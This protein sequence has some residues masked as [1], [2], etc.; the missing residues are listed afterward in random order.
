MAQDLRL[1]RTVYTAGTCIFSCVQKTQGGSM[2]HDVN[3]CSKTKA[4]LLSIFLLSNIN[5]YSFSPLIIFW[6]GFSLLK[7]T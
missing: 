4:T 5:E 7:Y 6:P 3:M 1:S 2:T